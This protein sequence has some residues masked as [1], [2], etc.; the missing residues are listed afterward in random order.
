MFLIKELERDTGQALPKREA[1]NVLEL[2]VLVKAL[3]QA[4]IGDP[5]VEMVNVVKPDICG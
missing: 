1:V 4:I 5:T 2:G 3:L